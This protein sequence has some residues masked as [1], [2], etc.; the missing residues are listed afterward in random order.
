MVGG[1]VS[2]LQMPG[3]R[4]YKQQP[5]LTK[6]H[7][8]HCMIT[9]ISA[10]DHGS[11]HSGRIRS[12]AHTKQA[13]WISNTSPGLVKRES[14]RTCLHN[15]HLNATDHS[16]RFKPGIAIVFRVESDYDAPRRHT[17]L[18]TQTHSV[19]CLQSKP[20]ASTLERAAA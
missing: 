16:L 18:S 3:R 6:L 9:K 2:C 7:S 1:G 20:G 8:R 19:K 13:V 4:T 12:G 10:T 11:F 15:L 14:P 17:T 5:E